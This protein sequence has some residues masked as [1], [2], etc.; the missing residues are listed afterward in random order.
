MIDF[1]N[2]PGAERASKGAV[3]TATSGIS[4]RAELGI[5]PESIAEYDLKIKEWILEK[6]AELWIIKPV[7][8]LFDGPPKHIVNLPVDKKKSDYCVHR[9]R[10]YEGAEFAGRIRFV[11]MMGH[12]GKCAKCFERNSGEVLDD[13]L[14]EAVQWALK[15]RMEKELAWAA[16]KYIFHFHNK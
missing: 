4:L 9:I 11:C 13:T 2:S 7:E 5:T 10:G 14:F 6:A 12:K 16:H 1:L 8:G 3:M 15:A